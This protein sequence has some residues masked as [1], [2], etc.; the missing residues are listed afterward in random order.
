MSHRITLRH[1]RKVA[2]AAVVAVAAFG[3]TA[4]Q[5]NADAS[6]GDSS[7]AASSSSGGSG[8]SDSG[9][10][11][12]S[13]SGSSGSSGSGSSGSGGGGNAGSD[14]CATSQLAFRSTHGMGE[15]TL[16]VDLKN[17][18]SATCTLQ[19]FP[20]VDLKS[21]NGTLSAK[22]SDLAA[23]KTSVKPGAETRFTLYYPPNTSGGSG[24]TFTT[25]VV[26]PPNETHSHSLP[27]SI[28]VPVT[29]GSASDIKVDP[30]GT[31]K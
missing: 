3:L 20:G 17:T 19:G 16:I 22:R 12:S 25:L 13:D 29:D 27:V 11:G 4:C 5:D 6:G 31:G 21:K 15:G 8:S 18:G 28:N 9:S 2:A 24:E 1:A 23:P 26:T 30:V 14:A 10:S 7:S